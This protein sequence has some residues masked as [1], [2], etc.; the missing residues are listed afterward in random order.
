MYFDSN[1]PSTITDITYTILYNSNDTTFASPTFYHMKK[2]SS[3]DREVNLS[4]SYMDDNYIPSFKQLRII[5]DEH[6]N[7]WYSMKD[8]TNLFDQPNSIQLF[9][10]IIQQNKCQLSNQP[11]NHSIA[12]SEQISMKPI[13]CKPFRIQTKYFKT[14]GKL[15]YF[16]RQ[17]YLTD[18]DWK[19][20]M[21]TTT[22]T[23]KQ[24]HYDIHIL[25][26]FLHNI[27]KNLEQWDDSFFKRTKYKKDFHTR[28]QYIRRHPFNR[29]PSYVLRQT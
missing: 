20:T 27:I 19:N 4:L 1:L 17:D 15:M 10:N 21:L 16:I 6:T 12:S 18:G 8:L 28:Y 3:M 29:E 25:T 24:K 2:N 22:L 13:Q 9:P 7:Y 14:K 23:K 11:Y 26:N 5:E